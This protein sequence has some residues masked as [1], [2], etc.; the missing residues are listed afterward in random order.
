MKQL[1]RCRLRPLHHEVLQAPSLLTESTDLPQ[2]NDD[3]ST[4]S[5]Q[6]DALLQC[7]GHKVTKYGFMILHYCVSA[8]IAAPIELRFCVAA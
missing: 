4:A 8:N 6:G 2:G 5:A 3:F 1:G 7:G